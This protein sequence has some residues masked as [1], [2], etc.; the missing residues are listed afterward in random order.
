MVTESSISSLREEE[1][2]GNSERRYKMCKTLT[3]FLL[4]EAVSP[5]EQNIDI[6]QQTLMAVIVDFRKSVI[7]QNTHMLL[8]D[9]Y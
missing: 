8:R 2:D 6:K 1:E 3:H 9:L 5:T 4:L 7:I